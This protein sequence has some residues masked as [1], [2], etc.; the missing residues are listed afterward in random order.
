LQGT[1]KREKR[2]REKRER[3]EREKRERERKKPKKKPN[4]RGLGVWGN[5]QIP[6]Q[7]KATCSLENPLNLSK[8]KYQRGWGIVEGCYGKKHRR[9]VK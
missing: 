8:R 9:D 6:F 1:L 7:T 3:K 2:E 4:Q 5:T